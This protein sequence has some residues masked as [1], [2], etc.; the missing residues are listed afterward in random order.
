MSLFEI[1]TAIDDFSAAIDLD[2]AMI[3]A[4]LNRS[5]VY[6]RLQRYEE[7]LSDL[8][9]ILTLDPT[10]AEIHNYRAN[11]FMALDRPW[12]ALGELDRLISL[13]LADRDAHANR[14]IILVSLGEE[15]RAQIDFDIA[16]E[17]GADSDRLKLT[18]DRVRSERDTSGE[19]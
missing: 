4:Y 10:Y 13:R 7:S 12:D 1:E 19:Q 11:I 3:D 2:P 5:M 17:L 16:V 8:G 18:L 15:E 9:E 6:V 14:A